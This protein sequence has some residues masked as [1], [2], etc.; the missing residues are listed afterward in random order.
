M[1]SV[2]PDEEEGNE[3]PRQFDL[4]EDEAIIHRYGH[5]SRGK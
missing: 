5:R 2:T 3:K 1:G 4:N